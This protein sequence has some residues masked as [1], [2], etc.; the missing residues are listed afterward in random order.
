MH[1][2][3]LTTVEELLRREPNR[4]E[5]L[6]KKGLAELQLTRYDLAIST[7][8]TALSIAPTD[9]NAR[10]SRA[11]ARLAAGQL[12]AARDDYQ[13]L[14]NSKTSSANA[15]FGLGTIAWR[16]HETNSATIFYQRYLTNATSASPQ[17]NVAI[18][19]LRE[20]GMH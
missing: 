2:Q 10:L 9:E 14:L 20:M 17:V 16:K 5:W 7:L 4:P 11:V 1:E 6:S 12:D 18:E 15:L 3:Q 8:T 13:Q 19:R